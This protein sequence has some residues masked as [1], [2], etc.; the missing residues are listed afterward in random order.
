[1]HVF[2][3]FIVLL[4]N[5]I[6]KSAVVVGVSVFRVDLYGF[7]AVGDGLANIAFVKIGVASTVV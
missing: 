4:L 7:G 5:K 1:M 2:P 3:A 6:G